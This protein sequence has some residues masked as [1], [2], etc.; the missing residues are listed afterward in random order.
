MSLIE[1]IVALL[2]VSLV[3]VAAFKTQASLLRSTTKTVHQLQIIAAIKNYFIQATRDGFLDKDA[4]QET[5][6]DFPALKLA[7][8]A[9][10]AKDSS[11]FKNI[12]GM[13]TEKITATWDEFG[14]DQTMSMVRFSYKKP[15]EKSD[16]SQKAPAGGKKP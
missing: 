10:P 14:R 9:T 6:I 3:V 13:V 4:P 2:I 16:A 11:I 15:E 12:S 5:T 1:I 7:Y 8:K